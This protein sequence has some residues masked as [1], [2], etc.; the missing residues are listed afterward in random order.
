MQIGCICNQLVSFNHGF[1]RCSIGQTGCQTASLR[2]E[3]VSRESSIGD[4][5]IT[6]LTNLNRCSESL[7][8]EHHVTTK[9]RQISVVDA[10]ELG[11]LN[12]VCS[13]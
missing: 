6:V 12:H 4:K 8:T 1:I 2:V 11:L 13:I 9:A 5:R 10:P 7:I 3:R